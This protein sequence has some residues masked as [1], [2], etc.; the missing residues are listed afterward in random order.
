[1][2]KKQEVVLSEEV[3]KYKIE[4]GI[5]KVFRKGSLINPYPFEDMQ[6]GDS[7]YVP[8]KDALPTKAHQNVSYC[9]RAYNKNH[10]I[11]IKI[12]TQ[13]DENGLRVWRKA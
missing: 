11:A 7:F 10:G 2:R 3:T 6:I 4:K 1:M 12:E 9:L 5:K 13:K 8:K